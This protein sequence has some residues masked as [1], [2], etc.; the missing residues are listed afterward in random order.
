MHLTIQEMTEITIHDLGAYFLCSL[1]EGWF[2]VVRGD[3]P[4][5]SSH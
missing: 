3:T 5:I 4:G 2:Q 1:L